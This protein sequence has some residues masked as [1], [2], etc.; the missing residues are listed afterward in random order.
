MNFDSVL[1]AC[2]ENIREMYSAIKITH[3]K[4]KCDIQGCQ[5]RSI[6]NCLEAYLENGGNRK[7]ICLI[8]R[9]LIWLSETYPLGFRDCLMLLKRGYILVLP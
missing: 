6:C 8:K 9:K 3:T 1:D 2:A 5:V 4:N 7:S